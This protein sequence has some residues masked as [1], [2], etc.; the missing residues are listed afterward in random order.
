MIVGILIYFVSL[1]NTDMIRKAASIVSYVLIIGV[2]IVFIPNIIA[3]WGDIMDTIHQMSGGALP[4]GAEGPGGFG[5]ALWNCILYGA[6][7][8]ASI[9]L[10]VAHAQ[11]FTEE[12]QCFTSMAYG[13]IINAVVISL[14]N[15][16]LPANKG[17][18]RDGGHR[19]VVA[20]QEKDGLC[21]LLHRVKMGL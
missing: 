18:H 9:G 5:P 4:V 17:C 12:K 6:Y 14:V 21:K 10:Y 13:F 20:A 16:G 7:H 3:E 1:F 19:V 2:L 15:F 8:V 11:K